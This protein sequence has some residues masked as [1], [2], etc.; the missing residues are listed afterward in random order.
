LLAVFRSGFT[1]DAAEAVCPPDPHSAFEA[2]A[3]LVDKSLLQQ[4]D[5]E[6]EPRYRML[7]TIREFGREELTRNGEDAAACR[8]HAEYFLRFAER[9]AP[10]VFGPDLVAWL[11]RL[12]TERDN[13]RAALDWSIA[14]GSSDV[15]PRIA[16]ALHWFWR[17]RGPVSEGRQWIERILSR[18]GPMPAKVRARLLFAGGD[19]ANT[20]SDWGRAVALLDEGLALARELGDPST[21]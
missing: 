10:A 5:C 19:L 18:G 8:A 20:Q 4:E 14:E 21:L 17:M 1:L 2:I 13:L 7:E 9:G 11:D 6:V 15:A 12:E 3:S 16:A